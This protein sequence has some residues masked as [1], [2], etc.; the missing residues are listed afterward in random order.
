MNFLMKK[1]VIF[2]TQK[3]ET[4]L[5]EI[6]IFQILQIKIYKML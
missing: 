5:K 1:L 3:L 4:I 2:H 6:W